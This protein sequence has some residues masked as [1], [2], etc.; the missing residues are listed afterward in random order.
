[1]LADV[2]N[3]DD[4]GMI[5]RGGGAGFEFEAAEVIGI[6]AGSRADELESYIA[7]EP[8]VAGAKDFAHGSGADFFE[9]P[10]VTYNLVSHTARTPRWHVRGGCWLESIT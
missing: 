6:L 7:S 3:G 9:N 8:F 10:V 5:K 2:V 1:M 4:V